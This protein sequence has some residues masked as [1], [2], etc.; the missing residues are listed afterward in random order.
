MAVAAT[1]PITRLDATS[2]RKISA[3]QVITDLTSVIKELIE[4]A[5]DAAA[6]TITIRVEGYGA[7]KVVVEDDGTGI[8]MPGLV[9]AA[10]GSLVPGGCTPLLAHRA[11]TKYHGEAEGAVTSTPDSAEPS[12]G[13]RGEALHSLAHMSSVTVETMTADTTPRTVAVSYDN[14]THTATVNVTHTRQTTGTTVTVE[15]LFKMLPVRHKEFVKNRRKQLTRATAAVK[16]YA[17]SHP[18]VRL[19]MTHQED[20][21]SAPVTLVSMSGSNDLQ[22][23]ITDVYGGRCVTQMNRVAW[24]CSV[25]ELNGY[26]SR[27]NGGGRLSADQQVFALDGRLVDLP[28]LAKA[29]NDAFVE[30][31]PNASQ[32]LSVAFFLQLRVQGKIGYD[33]NLAPNKRKVILANEESLA[34]EVYTCALREF[35]MA[36]DST[37]IDRQ[38]RL[39][40]IHAADVRATEATKRV[41][42]PVSATSFTQYVFKKEQPS[43]S[44]EP[45]VTSQSAMELHRLKGVLYSSE[46]TDSEAPEEEPRAI[47]S[48]PSSSSDSDHELGEQREPASPEETVERV[49]HGVIDLSAECGDA[50]KRKRD[51][52]DNSAAEQ[53]SQFVRTKN[54]EGDPSEKMEEVEECVMLT[55]ESNQRRERGATVSGALPDWEVLRCERLCEDAKAGFGSS[56]G[57]VVSQAPT[58]LDAQ[59]DAD[60]ATIFNKRSFKD[61]RVLGQFNHGFII[62]TLGDDMFVIDQH[63]SDEKYNYE[64]LMR[65]YTATAQPL[66]VPSPVA[67]DAHEVELALSHRDE[68]AKHGFTV[69]AGDDPTKLL[70]CSLPVLPYD[71][72]NATD[73]LE[74]VVQLVQYNTITK[75]LR[76]VWHSMATKACR[77]SIMIGTPLTDKTMQS[78]VARLSELEQP[79]NCPHGRPTLRHLGRLSVLQHGFGENRRQ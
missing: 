33:V 49:S 39:T 37:E 62:A 71:V 28:R 79:W 48:L 47:P 4:N 21:Q 20:G 6:H 17:V 77:T 56:C 75:P 44:Q 32:R 7:T 68:L 55:D 63:A 60:L 30:C 34:E 25:A 2:A 3:G 12:L 18:H 43:E 51:E 26:V 50:G 31:L 54:V 78:I 16:Q 58:R 23:S 19:I 59:T 1:T 14:T 53:E 38:T 9:D 69:R 73:V 76:A 45:A 36:S 35:R 57:G 65:S 13:F 42:A 24:S 22:R 40:Q 27:V 66:V 8:A 67:M 74:L 15:N 46:L 29:I 61:M 52:D 72:V 11:T 10:T 70:V 5:L 64:R 41:L